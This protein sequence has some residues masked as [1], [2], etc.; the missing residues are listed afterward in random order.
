MNH[1]V[2]GG[3][4]ALTPVMNRGDDALREWERRQSGKASNAVPYPQ[5]E[6]LHQ[7][8]E[9]AATQG[10][11]SWNAAPRYH[12]PTSKLAQSYHPSSLQSG[13]VMDEER[14]DQVMSN[15]RSAARGDAPSGGGIMYGSTSGGGNAA[16]VIS[17]PPQAYTGSM[18][19]TGNRYASAYPQQPPPSQ[20]QPANNP[21]S[22]FDGRADV[23]VNA[24]YAPM[25]PD[26]QYSPYNAS[27]ASGVSGTRHVAQP[28]Q[29]LAPAFYGAGMVPG[30]QGVGQQQQQQQDQQMAS[31]GQDNRRTGGMDVWAR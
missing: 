27:S 22:P 19:T 23:S 25:Q 13:S 8:A 16:A 5:L 6:L 7:Q 2:I 26:H 11:S 30:G 12:P 18:N 15:V 10:L 20:S 9:L 24:M 29:A 17:S 1:D 14:R 4:N 31:G 21:L 28:A 3:R